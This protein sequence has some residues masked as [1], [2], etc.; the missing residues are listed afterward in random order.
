MASKSRPAAK[1]SRSKPP[2]RKPPARARR[3]NPSWPPQIEQR[4]L[5]LIGLALVALAVFFSFV[6]WLGWDGGEVG[7]RSVEGLRWLVGETHHAAP[8]ALMLT[9][10]LLVMRP[11]LAGRAP[12]ARGRVVHDRRDPARVREW[13]ARRR[14]RRR[15]SAR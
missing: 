6:L 2:A 15:S 4:H 11:V 5:D 14:Q 3:S 13:H 12:A 1:R 7:S 9:G 8:L 10:A